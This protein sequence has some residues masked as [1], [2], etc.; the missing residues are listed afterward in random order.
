M[1]TVALTVLGITLLVV[2]F[3][4]D[5][6]ILEKHFMHGKFDLYWCTAFASAIAAVCCFACASY[7]VYPEE[8]IAVISPIIGFLIG[9]AIAELIRKIR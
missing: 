1:L 2:S 4:I 7:T 6:V 5:Q 8:G 9:V 3:Y